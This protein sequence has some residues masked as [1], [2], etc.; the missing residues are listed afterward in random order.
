MRTII[1]YLLSI[2]FIFYPS[3]VPA[4]WIV[5]E[6]MPTTTA[7]TYSYI[8]YPS[9][10]GVPD[11][12]TF[13]WT[14][15]GSTG[16]KV[17]VRTVLAAEHSGGTAVAV[18]LY[19]NKVLSSDNLYACLYRGTTLIGKGAISSVSASSW[20]GYTALTAVS[21]QSLTFL[22]TDDVYPGYCVDAGATWNF[23][24][25]D[26]QQTAVTKYSAAA[27]ATDPPTTVTW[28]ST[29]SPGAGVVLKVAN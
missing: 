25:R 14:G 23:I 17:Y 6:T 13:G 12:P 26:D 4:F 29:T 2:L 21:G 3:S 7:V 10:N 1:F 20:T 15:Y 28:T 8:G 19:F 24:G 5:S 16:D 11:A 27:W 18:N 22:S 9:T